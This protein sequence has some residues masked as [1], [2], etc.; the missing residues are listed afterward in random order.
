MGKEIGSPSGARASFIEAI[1]EYGSIDS[2]KEVCRKLH[3]YPNVW[4]LSVKFE[5]TSMSTRGYFRA[6]H[7]QMRVRSFARWFLF[8]EE[9]CRGIY[10]GTKRQYWFRTRERDGYYIIKD[11]A[12][13]KE[14]P[15]NRKAERARGAAKRAR[16]RAD[17]E[18]RAAAEAELA[19]ARLRA[20]AAEARL[21][22]AEL[23]AR[24]RALTEGVRGP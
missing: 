12:P 8:D 4:G 5:V 11:A 3:H 24:L 1:G 20:E 14:R 23:E 7:K 18:G 22:V 17:V 6:S 13:K 19:E 9:L 2:F 10:P 21:R 15:R 16:L